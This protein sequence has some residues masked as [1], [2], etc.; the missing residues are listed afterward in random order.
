M[1]LDELGY[2]ESFAQAFAPY[3]ARGLVPGRVAMP[4]RGVCWLYIDGGEV[5]ASTAGRLRRDTEW[6]SALP[7]AGDWVALTLPIAGGKG[8]IEAV[9]P[10]RTKFSRRV[11]GKAN[12]QQIVAA[13]VDTVLVVTAPGQ[14][15][16]L[17]RVERYLA[18]AWES[19]AQPVLTVTKTDL[20][21]EAEATEK[22]LREVAPAVP[23]HCV[24]GKTG[25]G[26]A[27]LYT[28]LGRGRTMALLGSSGVGKS[29]LI[30]ALLGVER[31]KVGAV[32]S[33]G[34]GR[35]TTTERE[36]IPVPSGGLLLDTPGMREIQIWE[37]AE[38]I[39]ESFSELE[40]IARGCRFANCRHSGEP[41][42]A[43]RAAVEAGELSG[44]RQAS[45]R[46]L[47][48]EQRAQRRSIKTFSKKR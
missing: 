31:Q 26:V 41:D 6:R 8:R 29:K 3:A 24:S 2:D 42:C 45:H 12:E 15:L 17:R 33:S 14:D 7:A 11:A 22:A 34:K 27:A 39:E 25:A 5:E 28:Y 10:R 16:N 13:N 48:E 37:A 23:L 9:L 47:G 1:T 18:L 19:G 36:L 38:G 4:H 43:V 21:P 46:K 44:E 20:D 35:H 32:G 30:N 40:T